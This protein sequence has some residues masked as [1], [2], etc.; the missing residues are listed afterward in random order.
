MDR[1]DNLKVQ[2][3]DSHFFDSGSFTLRTKA[4]EF[5]HAN[6]C[7]PWEYYNTEEFYNYMD[8]YAV[9]IKKYHRA[10]DLYA[11]VDAIP[12][13]EISWRNQLYL[14]EKYNLKPVPVI[15]FGTD[16]KWLRRY[17]K[18]G[19]DVIALG[20]LVGLANK[21]ARV[22][23]IDKAFAIV[24][25]TPDNKPKVKIHGF[26]V[27]SFGL[28]LRYPWWSVDSTTWT[29]I[30]A[31]GG[32]IVPQYRR[33]KFVFDKKPYVLKV[34]MESPDRH[35]RN[36]HYWTLKTRQQNIVQRWLLKIGVPLGS[37]DKDG[38]VVSHGV[39]TR[40]TE[41]REANLLYF[42]SMIKRLPSYPQPFYIKPKK[43]YIEGF[44]V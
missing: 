26:G 39:V 8:A 21:T 15:H 18:R 12:N 7:S 5:G 17:I 2:T 24:C 31:Y 34:S 38:E 36:Q 35:K 14:E 16:L 19:Y 33:G 42:E 44:K 32:I 37:V 41:R 29:K 22:K 43:N 40:H 4:T 30:G 6:Q 11:N 3:V 9:F 28:I 25:D 23:W 20:C 27:T 13:P 1:Y 10:I